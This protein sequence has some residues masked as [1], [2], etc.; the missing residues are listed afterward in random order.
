[1]S[2]TDTGWPALRVDDWTATRE[3]LHLQLQ[4]VGKIQL[5]STELTNHWWNVSFEVSARGLT[6]RLLRAS[7]HWFDAE[8][9]L[10]D[11]VLV[12]RDT[13]GGIEKVALDA[14]SVAN[15]Y[16]DVMTAC[17]RLGADCTIYAAP[18]EMSTAVPF[19]E[20]TTRREYDADAA[21]TFWRQ[22][23]HADRVFTLWRAGFAGK[24]SPVQ[25]FWGSMDLSSTRYSGRAA[26]PHPSAPPHCPSW[27]MIEA[28]SRENAAAGFWPG[29]SEEG[30]FYA[31]AYPEPTGY[32]SGALSVGHFDSSLGEWILPYQA[33]RTSADPAG[34]L[35]TF[36]NE[37]Y[38]RAADLAD[39]DRK[40]FDVDPNRL[41][42]FRRPLQHP[43][44]S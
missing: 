6:T 42:K 10:V 14:P 7:D 38:S 23:L 13:T 43:N 40:L 11:H 28:E 44:P 31:Y 3:Y 24:A 15:F 25:L 9:D 18:N 4:I 1:M 22:L 30:S 35:L 19:A 26:P 16:A 27:V 36:L 32:R 2:T 39:W 8:F 41:E 37:T 29:G 20:D 17:R 5:V 34:T 21:H 33:V 12:L